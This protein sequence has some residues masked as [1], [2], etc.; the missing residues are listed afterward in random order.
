LNVPNMTDAELRALLIDCLALWDVRGR[1]AADDSGVVISTDNGCYLLR[2]AAPDMHP[3]RWLLQTPARR[4]ANR[5]PRAAPSIGALLTALRNALG[6]EGGNRLRIG[7]GA[8]TS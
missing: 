7:L 6:A 8:P 4:I 5:P 2:R 1:V 3:V